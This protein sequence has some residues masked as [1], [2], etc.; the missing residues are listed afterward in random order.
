VPDRPFVLFVER[1]ALAM[2]LVPA[3]LVARVGLRTASTCRGA[4]DLARALGPRLAATVVAGRLGDTTGLDVVRALGGVRRGR[5][6][7][8]L[9]PEDAAL[10]NEAAALNAHCA[11]RP[12]EQRT[13]VSFV[14]HALDASPAGRLSRAIDH[15]ARAHGLSSAEAAIARMAAEGTERGQ[16]AARRLVSENTIKAQV[17]RLLAKCDATSLDALARRVLSA[18][19]YEGEVRQPVP[20]AREVTPSPATV[21]AFL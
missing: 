19:L 18:A 17:R 4:V 16:L 14:Q 1:D 15:L 8:L 6:L 12:L 3:Q 13:L 21:R 5:V 11:F 2:A 7:V 9:E 20:D 10:T